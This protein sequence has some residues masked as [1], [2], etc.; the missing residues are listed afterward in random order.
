VL[1]MDPFGLDV[2]LEDISEF[3]REIGPEARDLILRLPIRDVQRLIEAKAAED[4]KRAEAAVTGADVGM[5]WRSYYPRLNALFGGTWWKDHLV[6]GHLPDAAFEA[7]VRGY[8]DRLAVLEPRNRTPR[9]TVAVAIPKLL[10]G[11]TYYYL[12]LVSRSGKAVTLFSDATERAF[13]RAWRKKEGPPLIAPLSGQL[14]LFGGE[15][16][17]SPEQYPAR[18]QQF[19]DELRVEVADYVKRRPWPTAFRELHEVFAVTHLG[20]FRQE[21]LRDIVTV[22]RGRGEVFTSTHGITPRTFIARDD[23][24]ASSRSA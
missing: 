7:L 20:R 8:C 16:E 1:F 6:D 2:E 5:P 13:E 24:W 4:A 9:K 14:S 11:P 18:R 17:P 19:L 3:I 22:L 15:V 21:H 10:G 23:L 12:I